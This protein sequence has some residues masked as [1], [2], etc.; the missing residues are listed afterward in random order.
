MEAHVTDP[1]N[2]D[3][4]IAGIQSTIETIEKDPLVN[5]LSE[6][7]KDP[8]FAAAFAANNPGLAAQL[9][10]ATS[11]NDALSSLGNLDEL[12]DSK[13]DLVLNNPDVAGAA[14]L[15]LL[16]DL[17]PA[18]LA[19]LVQCFT[20]GILT[21]E[22]NGTLNDNISIN[23]KANIMNN[24]DLDDLS[25]NTLT[26]QMAKKPTLVN[27]CVKSTLS[28]LDP[29]LVKATLAAI[30]AC[31]ATLLQSVSDALAL[32]ALGLSPEAMKAA[33][34]ASMA[35]EDARK[36]IID[37]MSGSGLLGDAESTPLV[38]KLGDDDANKTNACVNSVMSPIADGSETPKTADVQSILTC[39]PAPVIPESL[40]G[41][42]INKLDTMTDEEVAMLLEKC[43]NDPAFAEAFKENNADLMADM[44]N[45]QEAAAQG[46][47]PADLLAGMELSEEQKK[48]ILKNSCANAPFANTINEMS[49]TILDD[50]AALAGAIE[51]LKTSIEAS[52][53][54]PAIDE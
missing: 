23:L 9:A 28:S 11:G 2:Y 50:A 19:A 31:D 24:A 44:A 17:S 39:D 43:M 6:A 20:D 8:M 7:M 35:S 12:L 36:A 45:A 49:F 18:D 25:K 33:L 38:E 32:A 40:T 41:D 53:N 15:N 52:G 26:L 48:E 5:S 13:L 30:L 47:S 10:A 46:T 22:G 34:A 37:V 16:G 27:D 4:L 54:Q 29:E 3:A 42:L 51:A 1:S 21:A 14:L